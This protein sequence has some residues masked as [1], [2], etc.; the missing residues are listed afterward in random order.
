MRDNNSQ[1]TL[2]L[3]VFSIIQ[4]MSKK[5]ETSI[6]EIN[7][8]LA[9]N[10]STIYKCLQTLCDIG[11][12]YQNEQTQQYGLTLRFAS[13]CSN[14][15]S[16]YS[17][18]ETAIPTMKKIGEITKETVHLGLRDNSKLVYI[19]KIDSPH[20]LRMYSSIGKMAPLYCTAIGK[21][22]LAF[23][24]K[25]L[26]NNILEMNERIAY[27]SNTMTDI[28]QLLNHLEIVRKNGYG[29]DIEEHEMHI[30]CVA[31]P[32]FDYTRQVTAA[33]SISIP[34]FRWNKEIHQRNI[35]CLKEGVAEISHKLGYNN[36]LIE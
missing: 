1:V 25:E 9:L 22:L 18:T 20:T 29:E 6:K 23:E 21:V 28:E 14:I 36:F 4:L 35:E 16:H 30:R 7:E 17:I 12:A 34:I 27:T 33:L 10:T 13:I 5:Q 8:S 15:L 32:I 19:Y 26:Q 3:K 2:I 24:S 31:M 11:Y